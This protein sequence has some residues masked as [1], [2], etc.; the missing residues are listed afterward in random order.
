M[1]IGEQIEI[2]FFRSKFDQK[3]LFFSLTK[4]EDGSMRFNQK[5]HQILN[6]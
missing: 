5:G 4:A 3:P 1:T 2:T 6:D